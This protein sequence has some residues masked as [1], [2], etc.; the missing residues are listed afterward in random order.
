M[1]GERAGELISIYGVAKK[2]GVS[3]RTIADTIFP[4]PTYGLGARRA[5]DQYYIQ[6][7]FPTF[8]NAVKTVFRYRGTTPPPPDPNRVM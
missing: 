7:A 8:V 3:V 1:V 6:K 4:Y 5:A 2:A